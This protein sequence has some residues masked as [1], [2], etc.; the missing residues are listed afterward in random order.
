[1]RLPESAIGGQWTASLRTIDGLTAGT[2]MPTPKGSLIKRG[3]VVQKPMSQ[4]PKN[5]SQR[6]SLHLQN[7]KLVVAGLSTTMVNRFRF[8]PNQQELKEIAGEI[9][10]ISLSGL[11]FRGKIRAASQSEWHLSGRLRATATQQCVV[12]LE[13]V[14]TSVDAEVKRRFVDDAGI[15][16]PSVDCPVPED[17][18]LELLAPVIDLRSL[19]RE[20]LILELPSYPRI[21]GASAPAGSD[22]LSRQDTRSRQ[23]FAVL[24][25]FRE[26]MTD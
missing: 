6:A 18:S 7:S 11:V 14:R 15:V 24:S 23:P 2:R 16:Y 17:D 26:R 20:T 10:A 9:Q 4:L 3:F 5:N 19:A 22:A 13:T 8:L 21:E 12:S 25:E 1:M